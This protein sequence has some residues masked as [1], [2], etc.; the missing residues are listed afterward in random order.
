MRGDR[1]TSRNER[2]STLLRPRLRF[3]SRL[4]HSHLGEIEHQKLSFVDCVEGQRFAIRNRRS[5]TRL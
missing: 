2:R 1:C 4:S 3:H 5:V